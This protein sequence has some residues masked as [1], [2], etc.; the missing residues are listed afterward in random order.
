MQIQT[1]LD[2]GVEGALLKAEVRDPIST[3]APS[4][5]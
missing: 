4:T 1:G 5:R 2:A 3:M